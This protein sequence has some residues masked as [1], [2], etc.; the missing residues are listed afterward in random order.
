M[1]LHLLG[2]WFAFV[3]CVLFDFGLRWFGVVLRLFLFGS[4]GCGFCGGFII[5]DITVVCGFVF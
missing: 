3:V 5:I 4:V 2:W 1:L